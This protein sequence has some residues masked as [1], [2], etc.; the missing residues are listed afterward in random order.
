MMLGAVSKVY[1]IPFLSDIFYIMRLNNILWLLGIGIFCP[2]NT[3]IHK[4]NIKLS[5][6]IIILY[7]LSIGLFLFGGS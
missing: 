7:C 5:I 1:Q 3:I 6:I 4:Y 2:I